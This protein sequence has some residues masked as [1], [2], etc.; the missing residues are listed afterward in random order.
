MRPLLFI[1]ML[2][3]AACANRS[4]NPST[5]KDSTVVLGSVDTIE[6]R[7]YL[8]IQTKELGDFRVSVLAVF[9]GQQSHS[10]D[11]LEANILVYY[12]KKTGRGDT[13]ELDPDEKHMPDDTDR[14]HLQDVTKDIEF[15]K[16][17]MIVG[18][19]GSSD[20]L[21]EELVGFINDTLKVIFSGRSD[22]LR[23]ADKWT[24]TGLT[25]EPEFVTGIEYNSRLTI[26]LKTLEAVATTPDTIPIHYDT[27]STQAIKAWR[28]FSNGEHVPYTIPRGR[29]LSI[30]TVLPEKRTV[31]M[32][33]DSVIL[34]A[35][36][37][38]V[39]GKIEVSTAG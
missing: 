22:S 36:S 25:P 26:S 24:I 28:I 31:I 2:L 7:N 10:E 9:K 20:Y 3:L 13:L 33:M 30:D 14:V 32:H 37:D 21:N 16:P 8:P 18:W 5:S 27:K 39:Q 4:G 19:E 23:R 35:T 34:R 17:A 38:N 29:T 1:S 6:L 12:N 11:D 15:D